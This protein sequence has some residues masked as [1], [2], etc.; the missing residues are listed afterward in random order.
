[1]PRFKREVPFVRRSKLA[2]KI[3][4]CH[5]DRIPIIIEPHKD[6]DPKIARKKFLVPRDSTMARVINEVRKEILKSDPVFGLF[7]YVNSRNK[8]TSDASG[9]LGTMTNAYNY[10]TGYILQ[11]LPESYNLVLVPIAQTV[12]LI[13][14]QYKDDDQFLYITYTSENSFGSKG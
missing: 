3:L 8:K 4:S 1:M 14:Q 10:S 13:Y 5:P 9:M 2:S 12:D 6:T 7:F 11:S